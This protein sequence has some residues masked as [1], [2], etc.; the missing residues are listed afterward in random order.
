M[1]K[2]LIRLLLSFSFWKENKN[3][4]LKEMLS[5]SL[6]KIYD[7]IYET[8]T[9]YEKDITIGELKALFKANNPTATVAQLELI[10]IALSDL[11]TEI[12][13]DVAKEII[14]KAWITEIGRQIA[15]YGISIVNG[16]EASFEKAESLIKR[17]N[18]GQLFERDDIQPVS[19][20]LDDI[21]AE[22]NTTTRWPFFLEPLRKV[23]GGVGPGIFTIVAARVEAG[24]TAFGVSL[25]ADPEGIAAQGGR[26]FYYANEESAQ[27]VQGRAVMCYT[28]MNLQEILLNKEEAK[29]RYLEI[30]DRIQFFN[31]R[32]MNINE[33]GA[34]IDRNSPDVVIID[35]LDKLSI[36]GSFAREDERLGSLYTATRDI[37]IRNECAGVALSQINA[38]GEGKSLLSSANLANART[39]KAAEGDIVIGLGKSQYHEDMCRI[40]NL[41]KNKV[42]G[43]H[44]EIVCKLIPEISRYVA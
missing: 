17:I 20:E 31:C 42:T 19:N 35:Q 13:E 11:P 7:I 16:K 12:S 14:K 41:I 28:G 4:I 21:L 36:N 3:R 18:E 23:A 15:D 33:I 26:V 5:S 39:S 6:H 29:E 22:I 25:A 44:N 37:L 43:L 8:H 10:D 32:G 38:E 9:R 40:L 30:K 24:K 2:E 34:H 27:R 1:D